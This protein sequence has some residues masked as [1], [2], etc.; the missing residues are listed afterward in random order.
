MNTQ[1]Q[2]EILDF[3]EDPVTS[4]E[5]KLAILAFPYNWADMVEQEEKLKNNGDVLE[6]QEHLGQ[7]NIM[8]TVV[9]AA[10]SS[11]AELA[12]T[13]NEIL[14]FGEDP[15][16]SVEAKLAILAFPYNWADMVE[17]EEK[18]K[19]TGDV[20]GPQEHLGQTNVMSTVVE[21]ELGNYK[22]P[23]FPLKEESKDFRDPKLSN[24]A[25]DY[26]DTADT[27]VFE[28][29]RDAHLLQLREK[30][31][32]VAE[33]NCNASPEKTDEASR[34]D[35]SVIQGMER[36]VHIFDAK[37]GIVVGEIH[38]Q[39][40]PREWDEDNRPLAI[41]TA[42]TQSSRTECATTI[43]QE[44]QSSDSQTTMSDGKTAACSTKNRTMNIFGLEII[45]TEI[46]LLSTE[47]IESHIQ[48]SKS[49]TDV[50]SNYLTRHPLM[51]LFVCGACCCSKKRK[52]KDTEKVGLL[53]RIR[54]IFRRN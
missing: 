3:G 15:V 28:K 23:A 25:Q 49:D 44:L 48:E 2:N 10:G 51:R 8:S 13:K 45:D 18:L 39:Y 50:E 32:Q 37:S 34:I 14:D 4:V 54:K 27:N 11:T 52:T 5:A 16:T 20:P 31:I 47:I 26:E 53:Q 12:N 41:S 29:E 35:N 42:E 43:P 1:N 36:L 30:E 22:I 19:N 24:E 17:Q 7:T 33:A 6:P 40:L 21:A 46:S 9:E 38:A